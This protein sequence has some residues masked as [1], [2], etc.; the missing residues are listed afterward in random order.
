METSEFAAELRKIEEQD[1]GYDELAY[2]VSNQKSSR[3]FADVLQNR[4]S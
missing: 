2:Q 4:C 3:S 1:N